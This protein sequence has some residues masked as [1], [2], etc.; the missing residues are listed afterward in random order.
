[1]TAKQIADIEELKKRV[2]ALEKKAASKNPA[3]AAKKKPAIY[4][5]KK[6]K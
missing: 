2:A 3:P 4:T 1:M 5:P 6:S